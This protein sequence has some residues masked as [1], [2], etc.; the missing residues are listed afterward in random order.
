MHKK[1]RIDCYFLPLVLSHGNLAKLSSKLGF[2]GFGF[3]WRGAACANIG[4]AELAT[5]KV[6]AWI[7]EVS[8]GPG[9]SRPASPEK[10]KNIG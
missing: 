8:Q 4:G 6:E 9:H 3:C 7:W 1:R 10:N 5:A 2:V